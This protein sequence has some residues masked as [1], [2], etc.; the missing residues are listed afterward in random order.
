MKA[1]TLLKN[2]TFFSQEKIF[3]FSMLLVNGGN[4]LYNLIL[5]R[6]LGPSAFSET[7][8]IVTFL[9]ILSFIGMTF[10][11][12]TTKFYVITSVENQTS[13]VKL[14]SKY[15]LFIGVIIGAFLIGFQTSLQSFFKISFDY[16]F[17][18]LG[19][20]VP[21]YF[22]M[23]VNRGVHQAKSDLFN[24]ANTYQTEM[25]GRF[26]FTFLILW[27]F[28]TNPTLAVSSGIGLSF[29]FGLFPT[30]IKSVFSFKS[31]QQIS[32]LQNTQLIKFFVFTA[33]YECTLII[34]NNSDILMV[35]HFFD[36][37][38]AGLYA[39]IALIGRMVYFL[40]WI[41]VMILLP[42]VI[43]LHHQG[44]ETKNVL[45][46][47]M[48]Y[49]FILASSIVLVTYLFPNQ[50]ILLLFGEQYLS[51]ADLLWKYALATSLFAL[52]NIIA[53]YYLSINIYWPILFS[54][55]FGFL[56][57]YLVAVYHNNLHTVVEMQ[58]VAMAFLFIAQLL[59][60]LYQQKK[61]VRRM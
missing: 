35:K 10:Q 25:L 12:V 50:A 57:I 45:L 9:L 5:G 26:I 7:A 23:S 58:I 19:I 15:A 30:Q 49:I 56:Q 51:V 39:S 37:I 2:Q 17:I 31:E 16:M 55:I 13:L 24:L 42:K 32:L 59:F 61:T 40:T 20:A 52:S 33:F 21:F 41:A 18:I 22:L 14:I 4:Y 8:L 11:V 29:I 34:I 38:Q 6:V 46:T 27:L 54:A 44:V 48:F 3:M 47:Y 28:P 36:D 53:Y 1:I 60:F 43:S